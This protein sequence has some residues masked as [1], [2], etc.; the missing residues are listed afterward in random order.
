LG[1]ARRRSPRT[2]DHVASLT[3]RGLD[4]GFTDFLLFAALRAYAFAKGVPSTIGCQMVPP[5][6]F[7]Y[8]AYTHLALCDYK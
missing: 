3:E 5:A 1:T 8:T 6:S 7:D 2:S 4:L